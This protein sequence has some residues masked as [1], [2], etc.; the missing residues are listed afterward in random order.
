MNVRNEYL[1]GMLGSRTDSAHKYLTFNERKLLM[2]VTL[3]G[4]LQENIQPDD[5]VAPQK[6]WNNHF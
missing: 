1:I 4:K 5:K 2:E 6:T 3:N